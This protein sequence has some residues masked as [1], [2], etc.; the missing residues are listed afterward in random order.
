MSAELPWPRVL[1]S[2]V[3]VAMPVGAVGRL[4]GGSGTPCLPR[5]GRLAEDVSHATGL[6]CVASAG[7]GSHD[8]RAARARRAGTVWEAAPFLGQLR[9]FGVLFRVFF[10]L[11]VGRLSHFRNRQ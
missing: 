6:A 1:P 5:G 4:D 9:G 11:A 2:G 10:V 3:C 8:T 7:R